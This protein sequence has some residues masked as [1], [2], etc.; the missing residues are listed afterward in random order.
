MKNKIYVLVFGLLCSFPLFSQHDVNFYGTKYSDHQV[1]TF[2]KYPGGR[3]EIVDYISFNFR[4]NRSMLNQI[5]DSPQSVVFT[6]IVDTSGNTS[7]FQVRN[8]PSSFVEKEFR[9]IFNSMSGW[10]PAVH[11][12][13]KIDLQ[14]DL[15]F[16]FAL[17]ESQLIYM[18]QSSAMVS[19]RKHAKRPGFKI[20]MITVAITVPL[21]AIIT[22]VKK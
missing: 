11:N 15:L 22:S 10:K 19:P 21:I 12:G 8:C 14:V 7:S 4:V 9:K 17:K 1:D 20:A 16:D 18:P 2:P 13:E 3:M 5:G 6:F